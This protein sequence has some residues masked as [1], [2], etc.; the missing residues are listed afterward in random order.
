MWMANAIIFALF[1]LLF[2]NK[3]CSAICSNAYGEQP[4]VFTPAPPGKTPQCARPGSTYCEHPSNYPVQVIEF[5]IKKWV[6]DHSTLLSNEVHTD[7]TYVRPTYDNKYGYNAFQGYPN[8]IHD[9]YYPEPIHIP[10]PS[11]YPGNAFQTA[12]PAN[13]YIP[14]PFPQLNLTGGF[15][16]YPDRRQP[17]PSNQQFSFKYPAKVPE[18]PQQHPVFHGNVQTEQQVPYFNPNDLWNSYINNEGKFLN[19]TPFPRNRRAAKL[20]AHKR[21]LRSVAFLENNGTDWRQRSKRQAEVTG[22][23]LCQTRAN[24]IMPRAAVNVKG[25]WMFVVN[26]PQM[27]DMYTQLVKSETCATQTCN[28]LCSLP[29]GYTSRC[30]QKYVQKRLVALQEGGSQLYT[31]LFWFPSCCLCTITQN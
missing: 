20:K 25:N 21:K 9:N 27:S 11:S 18:Q 26:M 1:H 29:N 4:C 17:L 16:G 3:R 2:N 24:Y 10:K 13:T 22:Q 19:Y 8:S 28:G 15:A 23:T 14:P 31:D 30:E 6:Y 5:L 12:G 7:Y